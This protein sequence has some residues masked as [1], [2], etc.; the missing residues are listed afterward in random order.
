MPNNNITTT[1]FLT[2]KI[3]VI[4][5]GYNCDEYVQGCYDSVKSQ[6]V[7]CEVLHWLVD[8]ASEDDTKHLIRELDCQMV[9]GLWRSGAA[10]RRHYVM[11]NKVHRKIKKE[12]I[13]V[14]LGMDDEL[15]PG[16]LQKIYE[17]HRDGAW[18][19]YGNWQNQHG[20]LNRCTLEHK[21]QTRTG[22]YLFTAPNSFRAG[23]YRR[24]EVERLKVWGEWQ[25][26]CTEVEVMYSCIE[27]AGWDRVKAIAEPIYM[28]RERLPSGTIAQYGANFKR[29]VLQEIQ[30]RPKQ[31]RIDAL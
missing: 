30:S 23:L 6:Q 22:A 10:D 27:M 11:T 31:Q 1:T 2:M 7:D 15:L 8:D 24:I 17:A 28:Y 13:I 12:D 4:S 18:V 9:F 5:T 16:A 3:H 14:L 20:K 19:T 21:N 26:V 29:K 25:H